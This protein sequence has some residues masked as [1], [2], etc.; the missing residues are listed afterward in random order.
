MLLGGRNFIRNGGR[1]RRTLESETLRLFE[2]FGCSLRRGRRGCCG[3]GLRL[4][5]FLSTGRSCVLPEHRHGCDW[6][7][8]N[9]FD[10]VSSAHRIQTSVRSMRESMNR[11]DSRI[12]DCSTLARHG[13]SSRTRLNAK[14]DFVAIHPVENQPVDGE[15]QRSQKERLQRGSEDVQRSF[16]Q[17][18]AEAALHKIFKQ[19]RNQIGGN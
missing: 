3:S 16:S 14:E 17:V 4:G 18:D 11:F 12:F 5:C 15:R 7:S 9:C 2:L 8:H 6:N 1:N 13:R 10:K 19:V